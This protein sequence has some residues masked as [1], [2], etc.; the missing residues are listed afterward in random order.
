MQFSKVELDIFA[1]STSMVVDNG[2]S[3]LFWKDR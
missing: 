2:E 3:T 1:A